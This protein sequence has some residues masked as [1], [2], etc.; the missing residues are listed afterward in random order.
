MKGGRGT[1]T[2]WHKRTARWQHAGALGD[3]VNEDENNLV[4][5]VFPYEVSLQHTGGDES[6]WCQDSVEVRGYLFVEDSAGRRQGTI[7]AY[8][9]ALA[10]RL[11]NFRASP[12]CLEHDRKHG[13]LDPHPAGNCRRVGRGRWWW[14]VAEHRDYSKPKPLQIPIALFEAH[15]VVLH[16]RIP[17]KKPTLFPLLLLEARHH[18]VT[19]GKDGTML[20]GRLCIAHRSCC[21]KAWGG[22]GCW[23]LWCL[24]GT[25]RGMAG[26]VCPDV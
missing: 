9:A 18:L 8:H 24:A 11:D 25:G 2:W 6:H 1:L 20:S 3:L 16:A 19:P 10:I 26:L 4:V 15:V 13:L 7:A 5:S 23:G 14:P 12:I 22:G 21:E 17:T